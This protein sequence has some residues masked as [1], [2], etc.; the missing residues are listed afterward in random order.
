MKLYQ[1]KKEQGESFLESKNRFI[2]LIIAS[3]NVIDD[4]TKCSLFITGINNQNISTAIAFVGNGIGENWN[5]LCCFLN[6]IK[7]SFDSEQH[8]QNILNIYEDSGESKEESVGS[9]S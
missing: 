3:G 4:R 2:K 6:N 9:E 5:E 8:Q 1:F 7:S